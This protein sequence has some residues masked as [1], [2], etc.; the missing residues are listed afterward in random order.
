MGYVTLLGVVCHSKLGLDT[1]YTCVQ[2]LTFLALAVPEISLAL[3]NLKGLL[4]PDHAPFTDDLSLR[5]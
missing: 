1:V 3:K 4:D 5:L 2:N